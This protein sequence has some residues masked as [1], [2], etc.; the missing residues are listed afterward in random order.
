MT[1]TFEDIKDF[2]SYNQENLIFNIMEL[3]KI[4]NFPYGSSQYL[5]F[6]LIYFV[7]INT[8]NHSIPQNNFYLLIQNS[9]TLLIND[10]EKATKL[11]LCFPNG[12]GV[13]NQGCCGG[14]YDVKI[15]NRVVVFTIR[16]YLHLDKMCYYL[17][18]KVY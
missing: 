12:R 11:M 14:S 13:G 2:R 16:R 1:K 17:L 18:A 5:K 8:A 4:L 7:D 10:I 6:S 9:L 15:L 3:E